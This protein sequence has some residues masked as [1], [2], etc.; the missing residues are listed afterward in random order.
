MRIAAFTVILPDMTPEEAAHQ[1]RS[2][3]YDGVEWRLAPPA[4]GPRARGHL[5]SLPWEGLEAVLPRMRALCDGLHLAVPALGSYAAV[6]DGGAV[7]R[8]LEAAQVLGCP[9]V[10]VQPPRISGG[11]TYRE[12]WAEAVR[13]LVR[14]EPLARR[15]RVKL[16]VELHHGGIVPSASLAYRLVGH[17]DPACVGVTYDPGNMVHEGYEAWRLGLELLGPYL[18]H[19]H[20]KNAGWTQQSGGGW[21][22]EWA[23]LEAGVVDWCAVMSDLRAVG[24]D[25]WL[26]LEDFAPGSGPERILRGAAFLRRIAAPSL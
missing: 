25:G 26:S 13:D 10:R 9:Q 2:A 3:G 14:I 24:Y 12:T 16:L 4:V 22:V 7:R 5:C 19:V 18:A 17:C 23:P 8:A 11:R 6:G 15:S 1:L 20:V 21:K